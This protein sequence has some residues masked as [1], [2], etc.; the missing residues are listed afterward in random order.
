MWLP[1]V[2]IETK[3]VLTV[4]SVLVQSNESFC[5]LYRYII[6]LLYSSVLLCTCRLN[7]LASDEDIAALDEIDTSSILDAM[8]QCGCDLQL[9]VH[10][11]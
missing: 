2:T 3:L 11:M 4:P 10:T 5:T 6:K 1:T 7:S 8:H 9:K